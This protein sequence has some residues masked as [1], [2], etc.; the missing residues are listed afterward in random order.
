MIFILWTAKYFFKGKTIK[1][2]GKGWFGYS[3]LTFTPPQGRH[4]LDAQSAPAGSWVLI[5]GVD[6]SIIKT[7]T[8]CARDSSETAIFTPLNFGTN[9]IIKLAVEPLVP[10]DLPKMVKALQ[11]INKSYPSA[12]TVIEDSGEHVIFGTGELHLDSI[13]HDLRKLFSDIEVKVADPVTKFCETV[14]ETSAL[15]CFGESNNKK[16]KLT[17][18]AEPLDK[19][20]AKVIEAKGLYSC[21]LHFTLYNKMQHRAL[22]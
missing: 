13:M 17:M 2:V 3:D 18:I 8:V 9:A 22:A 10:S 20:L 19:D 21:S 1:S 16:N 15:K 6:A 4:K 11:M 14:I 5:E 12:S 7:A